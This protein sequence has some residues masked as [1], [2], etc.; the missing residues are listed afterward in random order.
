MEKASNNK[1]LR[2]E[3]QPLVFTTTSKETKADNKQLK[4]AAA[5]TT[6]GL[7]EAAAVLFGDRSSLLS[8]HVLCFLD[9]PTLGSCAQ[10]SKHFQ[11]AVAEDSVWK[12]HLKLLLEKVFD[13]AFS[14]E[15]KERGSVPEPVPL[16]RRELKSTNFLAWYTEWKTPPLLYYAL[17]STAVKGFHRDDSG[18]EIRIEDSVAAGRDDETSSFYRWLEENVPLRDYYKEAGHFAWLGKWRDTENRQEDANYFYNSDDAYDYHLLDYDGVYL[19]V[20]PNIFT[21]LPNLRL[22]HG[23]Y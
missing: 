6:G 16:S 3:E 17:R 13:R 4:K 5:T 7:E 10:V 1:R 18:S 20:T 21:G 9:I 12:R 23:H 14:I 15:P 11:A 22:F 19:G 8:N 2:E